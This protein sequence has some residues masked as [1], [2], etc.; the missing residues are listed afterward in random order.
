M[1]E[2]ATPALTT[3]PPNQDEQP[4]SGSAQPP[5]MPEPHAKRPLPTDSPTLNEPK[6]SPPAK[7][8]R[9][10]T[11]NPAPTNILEIDPE[12]D[13]LVAVGRDPP[14]YTRIS[15][16]HITLI[17]PTFKAMLGPNFAEGQSAHNTVE[18]A[19]PLPEDDVEGMRLLFRLAHWRIKDPKE[20]DVKLLPALLVVCDKYACFGTFK[21]LLKSVWESWLAEY[22]LVDKDGQEGEGVEEWTVDTGVI[23]EA[24][25][26]A[27]LFGERERFREAMKLMFRH[28]TEV[29][30]KEMGRLLMMEIMPKG[31]LEGL[32]S[33]RR[34]MMTGSKEWVCERLKEIK[35]LLV[36]GD[37]ICEKSERRLGRVYHAIRRNRLKEQ[38]DDVD[39]GL[40]FR[41]VE[42]RLT[43]IIA[44]LERKD[45]AMFPPRCRGCK[46]RNCASL[47]LREHL[48]EPW[49]HRNRTRGC[50]CLECFKSG[51]YEAE[52][53]QR[54]CQHG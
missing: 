51:K 20:I 44:G 33:A 53:E 24:V 34:M 45:S 25:C 1:A 39:P 36:E 7:Q 21:F 16:R 27:Y 4:S 48:L 35:E 50:S 6:P 23:V 2:S 5:P 17:S 3:E 30:I 12:G 46:C 29:E 54:G 31:F 8:P 18:T 32:V 11:P 28:A 42:R 22:R 14:Q 43:G 38:D 52:A 26:M 9:T 49:Q 19:L 41:D 37:V 13:L 47:R 15:T 10:I 40:R